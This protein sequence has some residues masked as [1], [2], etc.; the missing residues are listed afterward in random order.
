[1][2]KKKL[3]LRIPCPICKIDIS[4]LLGYREYH[5]LFLQ[6][7]AGHNFVDIIPTVEEIAAKESNGNDDA[8]QPPP[9]PPGRDVRGDRDLE[10]IYSL[11]MSS[12]LERNGE[13]LSDGVIMVFDEVKNGDNM[14]NMVNIM[15]NRIRQVINNERDRHENHRDEDEEEEEDEEPSAEEVPRPAEEMPRLEQPSAEEQPAAEEVPQPAAPSEPIEEQSSEEEPYPLAPEEVPSPLKPADEDRPVEEDK[16]ADEDGQ[17]N[18]QMDEKP[19]ELKNEE[20]DELAAVD[21]QNDQILR[22]SAKKLRPYR[23]L[24]ISHKAKKMKPKFDINID[25]PPKVE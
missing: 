4:P 18:K 14:L 8:Y 6:D 5:R 7:S 24:K 17:V 21:E 2:D 13:H 12:V 1:L 25:N 3:D 19:L 22:R 16:P 11:M 15:E 10:Y 23:P 9:D 20:P